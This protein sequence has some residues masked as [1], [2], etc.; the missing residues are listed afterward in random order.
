[1][2]AKE[3]KVSII[4]PIYNNDNYI[5]RAIRSVMNQTLKDIEL[6]L[7]DDGSTDRASEIC[8]QLAAEDSRIQ[9]IHKKNEGSAAGRN[10]G[11]DLAHGEYIAF[12]ESDD[13]VA[14][15]MYEKLYRRAKE[16]DADIVKCGFYF[17]EADKKYEAKFFYQI[18]DDKEVFA[19]VEREKIFYYHASMWAGIYRRAFINEYGLRC[20]VTPSATYSDFSWM[21]M[22]YA[23]AKRVTIYHEGLYFYTY[24]NPNS[25]WNQEGRKCFYKP[26]HC[27][28]ANRILRE[29]GIFE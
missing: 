5:E 26:Y 17:C 12:V 27:L 8:D 9:V 10:Q 1:M 18:A 29:V 14:L 23:Y 2:E 11:I 16:T 3:T 20:I 22:T 7:I 4:F 15:D 25:S 19:P 24:D 13:C 28:Q 21:A 6:I